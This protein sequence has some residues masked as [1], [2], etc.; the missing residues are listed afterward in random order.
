VQ[1][2]IRLRY[3]QF[4]FLGTVAVTFCLF[5][6]AGAQSGHPTA[7]PPPPGAKTTRCSGGSVPQLEDITATTGI[8]FKHTSDPAKKYIVESMSGGVI[9]LD[10]D[11]DGWPDIYFT[12]A[13]VV[14]GQGIVPAERARPILAKRP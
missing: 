8:T 7:S 2:R 12:N 14:E 1:D 5:S 11:Q 10:Y 4:S 3:C 9:L 6:F 13:P